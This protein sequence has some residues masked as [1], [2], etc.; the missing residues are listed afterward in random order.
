MYT[1]YSSTVLVYNVNAT[2]FEVIHT[3]NKFCTATIKPTRVMI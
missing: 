3:H 1:A 2:V